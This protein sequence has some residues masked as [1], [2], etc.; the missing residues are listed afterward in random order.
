MA[1]L[2][3]SAFSSFV[4]ASSDRSLGQTVRTIPS[5]AAGVAF[6]PVIGTVAAL[7]L[8][9]WRRTRRAPPAS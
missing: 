1:T 6:G 9:G 4:D 2:D 8:L 7:S 3:I 5:L